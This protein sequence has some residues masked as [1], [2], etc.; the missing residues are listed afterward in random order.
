MDETTDALSAYAATLSD[1]ELTED[2][3]HGIV[4]CVVDSMACALAAYTMDAMAAPR[5]LAALTARTAVALSCAPTWCGSTASLKTPRP[6]LIMLQKDATTR[7][8][9]RWV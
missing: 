9:S 5:A 7:T 6:W 1:D 4:R 2:A 8:G 3:V